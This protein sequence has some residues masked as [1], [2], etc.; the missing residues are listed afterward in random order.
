MPTTLRPFTVP[1][2][3]KNDGRTLFPG[4]SPASV[5]LSDGSDGPI[6][7]L[8]PKNQPRIT[9]LGDNGWCPTVTLQPIM[10]RGKEMHAYEVGGDIALGRIIESVRKWQPNMQMRFV[11]RRVVLAVIPQSTRTGKRGHKFALLIILAD[12][13]GVTSWQISTS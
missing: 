2:W 13:D 10:G 11:R 3:S 7:K 1:K 6:N 4:P 9:S 5:D 12:D 8:S